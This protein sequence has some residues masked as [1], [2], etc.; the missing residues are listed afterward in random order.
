MTRAIVPALLALALA[1]SL[2]AL[3]QSSAAPPPSTRGV[4]ANTA[5]ERA[6]RDDA[7]ADE[8]RRNGVERTTDE[9]DAPMRPDRVGRVS[10]EHVEAADDLPELGSEDAPLEEDEDEEEQ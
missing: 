8:Q 1:A 2:P 5:A 7:L 3:G 6:M 10:V 4:D 9:Q